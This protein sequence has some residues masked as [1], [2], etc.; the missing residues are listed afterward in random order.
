MM[1]FGISI[2]LVANFISKSGRGGMAR[3]VD[4][5][6][7]GSQFFAELVKYDRKK[8]Y[9]WVE[10]KAFDNDGM[11]C[12]LSYLMDDGRTII[13]GGGFSQKIFSA[14][15]Q[16]VSRAELKT[17]SVDGSDLITFPSVFDG[18]VLLSP[19]SIDEYLALNVTSIYQLGI[20]DGGDKVVKHL[21]Q[22]NIYK[23]NFSYRGGFDPDMAFL[24]AS[25]DT[26]F[27]VSGKP[28]NY[29]MLSRNDQV[30]END[31][32]SDIEDEDSEIDF[33]MM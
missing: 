6:L 29:S 23:M 10:E 33:G 16:E 21:S 17:E 2:T 30:S 32:S 12:S 5:N 3:E 25:G 19:S 7:G 27:L 15:G 9:G 28:T 8:V 20:R 11:E 22:G 14:D 26:V 18:Q 4:F 24:L 1:G 31:E 13:P